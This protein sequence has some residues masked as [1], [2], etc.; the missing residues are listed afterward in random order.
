MEQYDKIIFSTL[1]NF[2]L[3]PTAERLHNRLFSQSVESVA[4]EAARKKSEFMHL[5]SVFQ[6]RILNLCPVAHILSLHIALLREYQPA[7][8]EVQN[9]L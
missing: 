6:E 2:S 3:T 7:H 1:Y 9:P 5:L 4:N 8:P